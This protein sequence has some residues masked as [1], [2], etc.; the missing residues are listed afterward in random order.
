M[1]RTDGR[2]EGRARAG[3]R[4]VAR[5]RPRGG[6]R[7]CRCGQVQVSPGACTFAP[8][9]TPR[10]LGWYRT[11]PRAE[12]QRA[13]PPVRAP[14]PSEPRARQTALRVR[15]KRAGEGAHSTARG[16]SRARAGRRRGGWPAGDVV[17]APSI[18]GSSRSWRRRAPSSG[19][20]R[21]RAPRP[22]RLRGARA[23]GGAR[24]GSD[25]AARGSRCC[26]REAGRGRAPRRSE[27]LKSS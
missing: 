6:H 20:A 24:A 2:N 27:R 1:C 9:A 16:E 19:P 15:G 23:S 3:G 8:S 10:C 22:R 17:T 11:R 13:P 25:D 4:E 18:G 12:R 26:S 14:P 5:R 21:K 7:D